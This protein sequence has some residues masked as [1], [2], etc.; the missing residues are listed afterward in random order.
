MD[1]NAA[2]KKTVG[3]EGEGSGGASRQL[4]GTAS[5]QRERVAVV[6]RNRYGFK[7]KPTGFLDHI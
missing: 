7:E 5:P 3:R 6:V 2:A 4:R 1:H